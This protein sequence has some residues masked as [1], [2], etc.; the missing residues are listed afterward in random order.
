LPVDL[1]LCEGAPNSPDVRILTKLLSGFCGEVRPSGS[2]Y[3][4]GEK[5]LARREAIGSL[6]IAGLLDGDFQ[7]DWPIPEPLQWSAS[8][9]SFGWR[10]GRKEVEN[11]IIDP[12]VVLRSLGWDTD[13]GRVYRN[14]LEAAA[15]SIQV[16]E[17]ARTALAFSRKRFNP[18]PSSWGRARGG[19]KH[20]FPDD[21]SEGACRQGIQDIVGSHGKGQ[22]V[23]IE[24]VIT[25]FDRLLPDF[26]AGG[27]RRNAYLGT[28]AGKDLLLA[29]ETGLGT[30]GFNNGGAFREKILLGIEK[31]DSDIATW[32]PEWQALRDAVESFTGVF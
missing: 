14:A 8:G 16:Y 30:F 31:T 6:R 13:R 10:W 5:I 22:S 7:V 9:T 19:D 18:L 17:A 26:R 32:V 1:L 4:M 12:E 25:Q 21:L 29:M 20:E 2:K 15:D 3:G 11:Y 24:E 27:V 23:L 28:Y